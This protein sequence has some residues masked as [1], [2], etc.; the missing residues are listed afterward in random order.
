MVSL[1]VEHVYKKTGDTHI[2]RA[3]LL[4]LYTVRV[5]K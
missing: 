1:R 4:L 2:K 3:R 5:Q